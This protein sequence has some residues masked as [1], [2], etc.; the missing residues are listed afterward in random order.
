MRTQLRPLFSAAAFF[1]FALL[2][3]AA[4]ANSPANVCGVP[5]DSIKGLPGVIGCSLCLGDLLP[6]SIEPHP[7]TRWTIQSD[8]PERF[9]T[10]GVL[11]ATKPILP[12]FQ[13]NDGTPLTEQQRTQLNNGFTTVDGDFDIFWFHISAPGD[14][15]QPRRIVAYVRNDGDEPLVVSPRQVIVTDGV[16]G[17]VHE[18]ESTL[19]ARVMADDWDEPFDEVVIQPGEGD[20]VAYSKQFSIIGSGPDRSQNVNSFGRA[21]AAVSAEGEAEPE[22]TVFV[23]GIPANANLAALRADTEAHLAAGAQSGETAIDL[24]Q[25]VP[26]CALSRAT[27]VFET[28][29]WR[30]DPIAIDA[31]AIPPAGINFQMALPAIQGAACPDAVQTGP[32]ALHPQYSRSDTVG[33]YK[34]EYRVALRLVNTTSDTLQ[35][36]DVRFGK[37]N[38][39]IGLAWQSVVGNETAA[40]ETVDATAVFT[41]WAGP[42]QDDDLPDNTLSFLEPLGGPITLAPCEDR[43]VTLR[44]MV[45]GNA[46]LPFT[47][48]V[49][50]ES[51]PA[52][53]PRTTSDSFLIVE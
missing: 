43:T 42:N 18:M 20:V 23:V 29:V 49:V 46:S 25:P 53:P 16:I 4:S 28:F 17:T 44:F 35:T 40:D 31:D 21:R 50:S 52:P 47:L 27:G 22:M 5:T 24:T 12:P 15:S 45:L 19:G 36:V 14:G 3:A 6:G 48:R 33:N 2:S 51:E 11:Y 13:T 32:M 8:L 7:E 38:A 41:G 30:N 39:D 34:I 26:G 9:L 37:N 10:P 1:P